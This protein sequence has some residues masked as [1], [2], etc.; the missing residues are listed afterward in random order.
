MK[1]NL[2][3]LV[4]FLSLLASACVSTHTSRKFPDGVYSRGYVVPCPTL[5]QIQ[6]DIAKRKK[7]EQKIDYN[8]DIIIN[9]EKR[10]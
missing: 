9:I 1:H 3:M 6:E 4:F 7:Y 10:R 5:E 8:V 2:A